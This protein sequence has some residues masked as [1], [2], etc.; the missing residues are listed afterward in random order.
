MIKHIELIPLLVGICVGIIA[1][2]F[3][4][5]EQKVNYKYPT[6]QTAKDLIYKDKNGI[7]FQYIPKE[8]DC[9]KNESKLKTFPL[10]L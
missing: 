1:I 2:L 5:P 10:S 3:V 9:D 6:P 8:V 4:K 7:C